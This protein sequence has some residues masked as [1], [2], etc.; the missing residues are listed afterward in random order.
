[1]SYKKT[2]ITTFVFL[3]ASVVYFQNALPIFAPSIPVAHA[4]PPV[5]GTK[6]ATPAHIAIA[7]AKVNA[8][9]VDVGIT[10]TGNLDVPPN[11]IEVGWYKYGPL[12]GEMGSAV[13]DGHV[14]NGGKIPGPFKNL[15]KVK[16][17]DDIVVTMTDGTVHRYKVSATDVYPTNK[18]PGK[19]IFLESGERYL[20]LITCHGKFIASKDTYD[21]RLVVTAVLVS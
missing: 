5:A 3:A 10:K 15:K 14:D 6:R 12:P 21:Q 7:K 1:M 4:A 16:A 19:K 17:G 18:F 9:I 11:Y 8:K 2:F 20:K 13:L